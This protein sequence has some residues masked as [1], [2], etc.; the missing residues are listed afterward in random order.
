MLQVF[1]LDVAYVLQWFSSVLVFQMHVSS[2]SSAFRRMLQVLHLNI[3]KVDWVLHLPPGFLLPHLGVSSSSRRW[4]G[5]RPPPV[6]PDAGDVQ[7]DAGLSWARETVCRRGRPD[8]PS[9][10]STDGTITS[11]THLIQTSY[12]V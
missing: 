10:Q 11:K 7:G 3:S 2:V 4:L 5:I 1:Y 6:L 9:V 8:A 12:R